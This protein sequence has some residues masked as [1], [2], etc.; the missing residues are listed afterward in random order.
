MK[1]MQLLLHLL[2]TEKE[3]GTGTEKETET[4]LQQHINNNKYWGEDSED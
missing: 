3:K 4:G 1:Q 2:L